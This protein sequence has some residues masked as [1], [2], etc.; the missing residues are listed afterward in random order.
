MVLNQ[1][2]MIELRSLKDKVLDGDGPSGVTKCWRGVDDKEKKIMHEELRNL[3]DKYEEMIKKI[4][5]LFSINQLLSSTNLPYSAEVMATVLPPNFKVP[6][7]EMY[8]GQKTQSS[9]W[10]YLKLRW[11]S[12]AFLGRLPV[13][14]F[15]NT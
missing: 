10:R 5:A 9:I 1:A 12:T 7:M 14:I 6:E 8:T 2:R 11:C 3:M 13:K 4:G 15:P